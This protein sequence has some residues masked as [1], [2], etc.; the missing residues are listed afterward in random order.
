MAKPYSQTKAMLA[1][2]RASLKAVFRSPS[3]VIF[4]FL[5]PLIFILVFG[6]IGNSGRVSVRVAFDPRSDTTNVYEAIKNISALNVVQKDS[7]DE[8]FNGESLFTNDNPIGERHNSPAVCNAY[9]MI[10]HII[11]TPIPGATS[12]T[13]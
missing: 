10:S 12:F 3:A 8:N 11:L 7:T 13:P 2:T 5:F 1:I 9:N 4:S 6:F